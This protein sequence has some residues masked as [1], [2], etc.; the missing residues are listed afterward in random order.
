[1]SQPPRR[2]VVVGASLAGLR[3]AE[4]ARAS[5]FD[6]Q[7]V[8]LGDET[9]LPYDRPPLSK[10]FLGSG[11][12]PGFRTRDHLVDELGIELRLGERARG[13]DVAAGT[14]LTGGDEV[15]YDA[16]VIATGARAR[17]LPT[18]GGLRGVH[19][20]RT[21][22]DARAIRDALDAGAR[23]VVIGA[24]FIGAE[25]ASS[26]RA[27]GLEATIV[28]AAPTPLVRAV[29]A[30][31]GAALGDLHRANGVD[32]ICDA[33][34]DALLGDDRVEGVLLAD[35]RRL[36]ADLVVV[37]IG[38]QP[39]TEWLAGTGLRLDDGVVCDTTLRT[40]LPGIYAAGDVARWFN[41]ATGTEQRLEHWTSAAEQGAVA[42]RNACFPE[43]ATDYATVPYFWSD[44]YGNRIQFVG[45]TAAD[46]VV[47][48]DGDPAAAGR[49]VALYRRDERCVGALAV[50][51]PAEIMKH[52]G[53]IGAG[54]SWDDA[55][56]F[57]RQ[58]HDSWAERQQ[59]AA[60]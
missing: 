60:G 46:E 18:A 56:G 52:R 25:I 36:P 31:M 27:R 22:D 45:S 8:L 55:V 38:S 12:E 23:T 2:L 37:G 39:N 20:L 44:W 43:D 41:A 1:M 26:A 42:A 35:G 33:R 53:R 34:V 48:V 3:A 13:L 16:L 17:T 47:V 51:A 40:D 32:L 15:P 21:L 5:G 19:S 59:R 28:E 14:V 50:N 9:H 7:V 30:E 6:G 4:A 58:R 49:W 29:G 24:G 11:H 57:A 10:E 54:T